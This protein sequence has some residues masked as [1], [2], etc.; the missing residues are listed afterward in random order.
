MQRI[1]SS[2]MVIGAVFSVQAGAEPMIEGQVR[3]ASGELVAGAQVRL[4]DL[5]DLRSWVGNHHR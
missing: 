3:L 2:L 1:L 5:R 4:F